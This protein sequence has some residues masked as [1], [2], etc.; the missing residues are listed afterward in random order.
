MPYA[1]G[2][3][4]LLEVAAAGGINPGMAANLDAIITYD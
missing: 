4:F 3:S 2:S 1:A